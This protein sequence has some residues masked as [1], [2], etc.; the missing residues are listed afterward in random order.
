MGD[1]YSHKKT[2]YNEAANSIFVYFKALVHVATAF[3]ELV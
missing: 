3:S 1:D 2:K